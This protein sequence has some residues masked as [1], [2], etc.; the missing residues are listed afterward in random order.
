MPRLP[1][2][3]ENF[4]RTRSRILNEAATIVGRDGLARLSMRSLGDRMGMTPGALYRYF[5]SKKDMLLSFWDEALT[6][7]GDRFAA[8]DETEP[9]AT[10]AIR[11]MLFAYGTFCLEDHDRFRLLFLENDHGTVD[12]LVGRNTLFVPYDLILRRV[13]DALKRGCFRPGD[14][15]ALT[16]TLWAGL[17]GA[18]TLLVTVR[19]IDFGDPDQ[20]LNETVNILMRG[21]SAEEI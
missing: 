21:L 6:A 12:E 3:E 16:N 9:R 19:E 18:V 7:L 2:S 13:N 10:Q 14:G 1:M 17:H 5:P 11:Q 4:N 15:R 20:F 8:I